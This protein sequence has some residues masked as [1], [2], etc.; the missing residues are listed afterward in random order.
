MSQYIWWKLLNRILFCIMINT[1]R[2]QWWATRQWGSHTPQDKLWHQAMWSGEPALWKQRESQSSYQKTCLGNTSTQLGSSSYISK[3]AKW[4]TSKGNSSRSSMLW[5]LSHTRTW[6]EWS[7]SHISMLASCSNGYVCPIWLLHSSSTTDPYK[8]NMSFVHNLQRSQYE[9]GSE[10]I[11]ESL[12]SWCIY[13][14]N[15]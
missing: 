2:V 7:D 8:H 9:S 6:V 5:A 1:R 10:D 3:M 13:G 14:M 11:F 15:Q 12:T 4:T